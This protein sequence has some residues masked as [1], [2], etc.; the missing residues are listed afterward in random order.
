MRYYAANATVHGPLIYTSYI[1]G[2]SKTGY[3]YATS[4]YIH[5]YPLIYGIS[6]RPS[7]ASYI[8]TSKHVQGR[9][10]EYRLVRE[11]VE[12]LARGDTPP[13]PYV[14]PLQPVHVDYVTIHTTMLAD[15]YY[16]DVRAKPKT[17]AP[18]NQNYIA[19]KPGSRFRTF[20]V[21]PRPLPSMLYLSVGVKRL[22]I[23]QLRLCEYRP[24][25]R[26]EREAFSTILVNEG[27]TRLF[28]YDGDYTLVYESRTKP[29]WN[30]KGSRIAWLRSRHLWR[31]EPARHPCRG[32]RKE[33]VIPLPPIK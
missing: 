9:P 3:L 14:F 21:S 25:E 17:V 1:V 5:N 15:Q 32:M 4:P 20:I 19:I 24:V 33:W 27:D 12:S 11:V 18:R 7:E 28:G 16:F 2:S 30:P 10:L 8:V 29:S 6:E 31:L 23:I 22:G 13:A 26:M